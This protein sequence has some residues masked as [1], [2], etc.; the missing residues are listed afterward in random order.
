MTPVW[1]YWE[2]P[3][4]PWIRLCLRTIRRHIPAVQ[5]LGPRC[6][7]DLYDEIDVPWATITAQR[8]NVKSDFLRAY[9][10]HSVGGI[11]IDAD[12]IAFRDVR[13]IWHLLDAADFVSYRRAGGMYCSALI[14]AEPDS[15]IAAEY[16]GQMVDRLTRANGRLGRQALG[17]T[18]LG[19]ACR[20]LPHARVA[21]IP[22]RLVH[23]IHRRGW[24]RAPQL[25][26]PAGT[27]AP[28]DDAYTCM[29]TH[30]ALG[31]LR[32][33]PARKLLRSDTVLGA[34]FR[35]ALR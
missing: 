15:P 4:P 16:Y 8:P 21:R 24:G 9:L 5:I 33:W 14:A 22:P 29:L 20:S 19:K 27:W 26:Q 6:F 34:S 1:T 30:R 25:W 2:G 13:P 23:Q 31:P 10:L 17:P 7:R 3:K 35:R 32:T 18:L 28:P 11:W 12:A